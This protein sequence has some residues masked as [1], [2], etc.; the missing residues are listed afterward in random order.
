M[1]S[2]SGVDP[3]GRTGEYQREFLRA[4]VRHAYDARTEAANEAIAAA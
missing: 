3:N 1:L 4:Y 2:V